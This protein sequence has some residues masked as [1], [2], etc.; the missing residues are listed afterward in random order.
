LISGSDKEVAAEIPGGVDMK[1]VINDESFVTAAKSTY[2]LLIKACRAF[3][4]RHDS[5]TN[6]PCRRRMRRRRTAAKAG[7]AAGHRSSSAGLVPMGGARDRR[8]SVFAHGV[9]IVP[10]R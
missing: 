1:L 5:R 7:V 2:L 9:A 6:T 8:G 10:G 4:R 3:R